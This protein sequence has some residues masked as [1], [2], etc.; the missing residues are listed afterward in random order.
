MEVNAKVV[1]CEI[2][3]VKTDGFEYDAMRD[4]WIRYILVNC[5]KK[6]IFLTPPT[7]D[8]ACDSEDV[9]RIEVGEQINGMTVVRV[10]RGEGIVTLQPPA[11]EHESFVEVRP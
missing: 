4:A 5:N 7:V 8:Y 10:D 11:V 6:T 2:R 1:R 9:F 3:A